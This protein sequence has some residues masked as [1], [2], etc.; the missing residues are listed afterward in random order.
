ME[1]IYKLKWQ[2]GGC[3]GRESVVLGHE[4]KSKEEFEKDIQEA[5]R[6]VCKQMLETDPENLVQDTFDIGF[7]DIDTKSVAIG[8][9]EQL[10]EAVVTHLTRHEGYRYIH[11]P[12]VRFPHHGLNFTSFV[13]PFWQDF[14]GKD[15]LDQLRNKLTELDKTHPH[16]FKN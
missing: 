6:L 10:F 11:I 12:S 3:M 5:A 15:L 1:N 8:G 14:L 2:T 4:T 13:D 7:E 16:L 9:A